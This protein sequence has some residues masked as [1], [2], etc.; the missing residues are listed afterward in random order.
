MFK[1]R[2]SHP[3]RLMS[4]LI[5]TTTLCLSFS[6]FSASAQDRLS[7][8]GRLENLERQLGAMNNRGVTTAPG[9]TANLEVRLVAVEEE[10]RRFNGRLEEL[11]HEQRRVSE[12]FEALERDMDARVQA[13]EAR[14]PVAA[15]VIGGAPASDASD[16]YA[17]PAAQPQPTAPVI[18]P[19]Q[20][21]A[22]V[23][24]TAAPTGASSQF[25][26]AREH[27][28]A[29][30]RLLN[31]SDYNQAGELF[32]TFIAAYPKDVLIGNAYY[33]LGETHYVRQQFAPAAEQ[34]RLGFESMPDGPKAPDNLLK[35]GMS[36]SQL[37][38]KQ[39]ACVVLSQLEKKYG[40]Q[41]QVIARKATMESSR[42]QCR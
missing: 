25:S 10:L 24:Q 18:T 35:L 1:S 27:Y 8:M 5:I 14:S 37:G 22:P 30:F 40:S 34:F 33:W 16:P 20:E 28:D 31:Q 6:A 2:T 17:T 23:V 7:M 32:K 9:N 19:V 3:R 42:L 38:R 41:S 12:K 26:N 13:L 36:L 39:E 29:A 21:S 11:S 15:P 4:T